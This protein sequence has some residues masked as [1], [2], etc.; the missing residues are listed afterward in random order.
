M[1]RINLSMNQLGLILLLARSAMPLA[2]KSV[3]YSQADYEE[4][5]AIEDKIIDT[6]FKNAKKRRA[7]KLASST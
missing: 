6:A 3:V 1:P 2:K 7:K 5:T 4:L